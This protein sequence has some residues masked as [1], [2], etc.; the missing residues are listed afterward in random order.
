MDPQPLGPIDW[1]AIGAAV[2]YLLIAA[3]L[4]VSAALALILGGVVAPLLAGGDPSGLAAI[5][6][7]LLLPLAAGLLL[8][9]ALALGRGLVLAVE[10]IQRYYP[11]FLI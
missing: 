6:R 1:A 9:A 7:R 2:T 8:L 11:R 5:P 3:G 4:A 10:A